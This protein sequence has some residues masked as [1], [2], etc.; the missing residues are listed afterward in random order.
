MTCDRRT[1]R[2][3]P[4]DSI[5]PSLVAPLRSALRMMPLVK[6]ALDEEVKVWYALSLGIECRRSQQLQLRVRLYF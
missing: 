6:D 5:S 2:V 1:A 4:R 3:Q